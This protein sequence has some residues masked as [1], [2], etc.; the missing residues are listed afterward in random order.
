MR[1]LPVAAFV[2]AVCLVVPVAFAG[3]I[4]ITPTTT[5]AAETGNNTSTAD[6]FVNST[7]GN[8]GAGNVSKE[9]LRTLLFPGFSGKV[10]VNWVPWWGQSNH[11]NIGYS[12]ASATQLNKQVEDMMSRDV[13]GLIVDWWNAGQLELNTTQMMY[14]AEQHAPFMF[15]LMY[16]ASQLAYATTDVTTRFIND[17]NYAAQHYYPSPAYLKVNGRPVILEFGTELYAIDWSRVQAGVQGNPLI[18][19]RN[20]GGF[21]K[22]MTSGG[23]AWGAAT[24]A[25]S[26]LDY[27]YSHALAA[28]SNLMTWG[29]VVKGFNDSIAAWGQNRYVNQ[30]CGQNWISEAWDAGHWYGGYSSR[31]NAVQV[32]TW[33]DYEE[34]TE[35]ESGIDNCVAVTA[36][37]SG[38]N[39]NWSMTGVENTIHHYTVFISSDGVNLMLLGEVASGTHSF[40]LSQ[41][42]FAAGTYTLYVKAVGQASIR[43]QM[44]NSTAYVVTDQAPR[45]SVAVSPSSGV[46]PASMTATATVTPGNAP[47][48]STVISFGDGATANGTTVSHTYT[49]PG[50]YAVTATVTDTQGGSASSTTGVT[51]VANQPP[52][53]R[54]SVSPSSGVA[55]MTVTASTAASTDPDGTIASSSIS[56]GDGASAAGPTAAHRYSA[57]GSYVVT[58]TVTDNLGASSTASATVNVAP[59]GLTLASPLAGSVNPGS[60]HVVASAVSGNPITAIWIYVDN[61]VQYRTNSA[62]VD[63][64]LTLS[65]GSHFM[66]AQAWDSSGALF[67][68]TATFMVNLP[69]VASLALT[70]SSGYAPA[71]VSASTSGST[72]TTGAITGSTINFGDGTVVTGASGSHVYSVAGT[73]TVTATVTDS[74]GASSSTSRTVTV[75]P[76]TVTITSPASGATLASPLRVT[77]TAVSGA[78]VSAIWVYVD[79]NVA[80]KT[81]SNS[82]DAYINVAGGA[83]TMTVKAWDA[84][85]AL[86]TSAVRITI[87]STSGVGVAASNIRTRISN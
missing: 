52:L 86:F 39:L 8:L 59:A 4:P 87:S 34:G 43:N 35:I 68:Q 31:L 24:A 73:Y 56:F 51:V 61:V 19:F 40:D 64:Y 75:A 25:N 14:A 58:A 36:T 54:L 67:R 12:E 42:Q 80:Y 48:A 53:A 70:Q 44:S 71:T 37:V 10:Y 22:A 15:A 76:P 57:A 69:P 13:D 27:F 84:T 23:Y 21:T 26:Y 30:Q 85:G 74:Y 79:T 16:D 2:M 50:N 9:S 20:A 18:I 62:S 33:N 46:A 49:V 11:I 66:S 6:S 65:G 5:L 45:I 28:P 60:V 1:P 72:D 3:T 41:F 63:T 83:H 32:A 78:P 77:A 55:P 38:T 82:V 29:A 17:L 81:N 47:V 7:N